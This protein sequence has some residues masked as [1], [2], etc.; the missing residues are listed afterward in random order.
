MEDCDIDTCPLVEADAYGLYYEKIVDTVHNIADRIEAGDVFPDQYTWELKGFVWLQGWNDSCNPLK[1]EEYALNL[2]HFVR[3]IRSDLNAPDL[4]IVIGET[5][6][7]GM[8]PTQW[9]ADKMHKVQEFRRTTRF[10]ITNTY[11]VEDSFPYD[12]GN[13][14]GGRADSVIQIG[15][16][17][18]VGMLN[19]F[20]D[21]D[22]LKKPTSF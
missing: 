20:E 16:A 5:G 15:K 9:S 1:A 12:E 8:F 6:Q 7:N 21:L 14:F 11:F 19:L 18:G 3:D 13:H 4:P 22:E 2:E 17:L 10:V